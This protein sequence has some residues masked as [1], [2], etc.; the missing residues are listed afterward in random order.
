MVMIIQI[1]NEP[2]GIA[3]FLAVRRGWS[4]GKWS[5]VEIAKKISQRSVNDLAV[6]I[7]QLLVFMFSGGSSSDQPSK[8]L[9]R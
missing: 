9:G 6:M 7:F 2:A 3:L 1:V 8:S 5:D 4:G